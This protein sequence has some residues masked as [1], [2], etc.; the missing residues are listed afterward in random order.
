MSAVRD[1][2]IVGGGP[3][4]LAAAVELWKL[5]IHDILIVEREKSLGGILRQCIHEGFGLTRFGEMLSGPEYA[6]RFIDQV[7]ELGIPY[8]VDTTVSGID[9][10]KNVT[11]VSKSGLVVLKAKAIIFAMGCRERPRGALAIPG[12]RPSGVFTAGVAQNY[13]NLQNRM[14]GKEIVILGSGDI[15]MIMARRLTLEGAHVKGVYEILP[16]PSG[17]A[18]NIHQCLDDFDIPLHLSHTVTE[19]HG[20]NR[21]SGMT[22]SKVDE[23]LQPIPG[24]EERIDCDTLI[25]S[26]GLIPEN[27][28][29]LDAGITLNRATRGAVVDQWMQTDRKGF[30]SC[31][32]VLHV[33]DVVD[34]V[35]LEAEATARA[36]ARY[37]HDGYL[38]E[39]DIAVRAGENLSHVLPQKVDGKEDVVFSARSRRK[40]S[41]V[42]LEIVQNGTV[43]SRKRV[44][45][46]VPA[47]MLDI[48]VEKGRFLE[49]GDVEVRLV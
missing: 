20:K 19:I 10:E 44:G 13:I 32:N 15:G 49:S 12:E 2:V 16:I 31:G 14:I 23:H 37:V 25:L 40:L 46:A 9:E 35:S 3:A 43:I 18:R 27:E 17:L 48:R 47:E 1:V 45:R 8:F 11:L 22:I 42:S 39:C 29:A 36:V 6:Q 41:N 33:H 7:E 5:G 24:T 30:F 26:V 34:F 28:L 21:L 38:P 4:G